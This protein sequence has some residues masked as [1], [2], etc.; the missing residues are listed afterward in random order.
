MRSSEFSRQETTPDG[1]TR[2][3]FTTFLERLRPLPS[4]AHRPAPAQ[5]P[6]PSAVFLFPYTP[7]LH[8]YRSVCRLPLPIHPTLA[9]PPSLSAFF[10]FP[11][12]PRPHDHRL[13]PPPSSFRPRTFK[14]ADPDQRQTMNPPHPSAGTTPPSDAGPAVHTHTTKAKL[15]TCRSGASKLECGHNP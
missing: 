1:T 10:L 2:H 5:P 15:R 11:N 4:A 3:L 12:A 8:D 6:S 13:R 14:L 9:R 7:S